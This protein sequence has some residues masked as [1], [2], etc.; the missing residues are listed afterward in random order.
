MSYNV[1]LYNDSI[2]S[3][4]C[5]CGKEYLMPYN[6]AKTIYHFNYTS[7]FNKMADAAGIYEALF[8]INRIKAKQAKDIIYFLQK[9]LNKLLRDPCYYEKFNDP[10]GW[11][12]YST[13]VETVKEYLHACMENPEALI[14]IR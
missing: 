6:I 4:K 1:Y 11:E 14:D 7:N 5:S 12:E 8:D 9:G 3:I 13:F 2:K 10:E